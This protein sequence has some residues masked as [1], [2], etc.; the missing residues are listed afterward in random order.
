MFNRLF[1]YKKAQG[2]IESVFAIGVLGLLMGGAIVLIVMGFSN[3][4]S[5]FDRRKAMELV[6]IITE[7]L[8]E[9][10]Q[11][12]PESFWQYHDNGTTGLTKSGFPGYT[13]SIG[14]TNISGDPNYPNC[15]AG[16]KVNCAEVNIGIGWSGNNPQSLTVSRFFSKQ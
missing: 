4:Q 3:R 12:D 8:I 2:V 14:Y 1:N 11:S 16:G 6:T 7:E 10:S 15:G 5:G 9:E 13:Y